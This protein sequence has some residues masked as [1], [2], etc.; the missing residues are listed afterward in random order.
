M[1]KFKNNLRLLFINPKIMLSYVLLNSKSKIQIK[2]QNIEYTTE[3]SSSLKNAC[4]LNNNM[5]LLKLINN[6]RSLKFKLY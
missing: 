2:L 3:Y 5:F 6:I 1:R 4:S